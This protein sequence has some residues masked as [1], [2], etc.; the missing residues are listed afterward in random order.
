MNTNFE[1]VNFSEKCTVIS[2][3]TVLPPSKEQIKNI[4]GATQKKI[5]NKQT[6]LEFI[7]R[8]FNLERGKFFVCH[9]GV[10][11]PYNN[12]IETNLDFS[13]NLVVFPKAAWS[14]PKYLR[15]EAYLT[16]KPTINGE[17]SSHVKL[18]LYNYLT[19]AE[20]FYLVGIDL[21]HVFAPEP[22]TDISSTFDFK[23]TLESEQT[24]LLD[25]TGRRGWINNQFELNELVARPLAVA[26]NRVWLSFIKGTS[27]LEENK[28]KPNLLNCK[29]SI[30]N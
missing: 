9:Y 8:A 4:S 24:T 3:C 15:N 6:L 20:M 7:Q 2:F 13:K 22:E 23:L 27:R 12:K 14:S 1:S 17:K 25:Y 26:G 16:V 29:K 11:Q 21:R 30:K 10:S 18:E 5:T 19:T 28:T